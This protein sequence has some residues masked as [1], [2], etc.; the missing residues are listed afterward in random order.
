MTKTANN[1]VITHFL[2]V[3]I[4]IELMNKTVC[5]SPLCRYSM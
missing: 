3:W 5:R 1:D 2:L 4:V